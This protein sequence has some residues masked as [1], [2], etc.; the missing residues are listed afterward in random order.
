[1]K[2]ALITFDVDMCDYH[3][4][5]GNLDEMEAVWSTFLQFCREIPEL[6]T[7][8]FIRIDSH[9]KEIFGSEEFVFQKHANKIQWLRENGHEIGWHFH[10]YRVIQGNWQQNP[11]EENVV[12][13]MKKMWPV[14]EKNKLKYLRMGW[15][16]HSN[17]SMK[18]AAEIGIVADSSAF[19]RPVYEWDNP[20]RNWSLTG[21]EIYYPSKNNYQIQEED[22]YKMFEIPLS[23]VTIE[24]PG[25]T[26]Q[27]VMRYINLTYHSNVFQEAVK[28]HRG[29]FINLVC[30]PY[31]FLESDKPHALMSF[32][33]ATTVENLL[34]LQRE[35]FEF[36]TIG[37]LIS[38]ITK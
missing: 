33:A 15:A 27:D 36:A 9:M 5:S 11:D 24:S 10:S 3:T 4:D 7:T 32:H 13:E 26:E 18:T 28:K 2:K 14:A 16:Y 1:M 34:W 17:L 30:H 25:D 6:K 21:Q 20:Y 38:S 31:E 12:Q 29:D 23:T 8:W 37:D 22:H 35:G 19:P